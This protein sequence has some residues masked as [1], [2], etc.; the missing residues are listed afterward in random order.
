MTGKS[1]KNIPLLYGI[2]LYWHEIKIMKVWD[3]LYLYTARLATSSALLM[4]CCERFPGMGSGSY[5]EK[6]HYRGI[7]FAAGFYYFYADV[8]NRSILLLK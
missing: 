5:P 4:A 2:V 7:F 1:E 3:D 8:S 6:Y